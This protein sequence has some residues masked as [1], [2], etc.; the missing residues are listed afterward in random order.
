MHPNAA[1]LEPRASIEHPV[2]NPRA[3]REVVQTRED[4]LHHRV[5]SER[6]RAAAVDS[7]VRDE[8]LARRATTDGSCSSSGFVAYFPA[9]TILTE[10]ASWS[11]RGFSFDA[12]LIAI[13]EAVSHLISSSLTTYHLHIFTDSESAAKALFHTKSGRSQLLSLNSTLRNTINAWTAA[14]LR[15]NPLTGQPEP[16]PSYWG[17]DYLHAPATHIFN[18]ALATSFIRRFGK[19]SIVTF[20]RTARVINNHTFTGAYRAKFR[21]RAE[22][23]TTCPCGFFPRGTPLHDRHHVL[24]ECPFYYRGDISQL[25][26]LLELDPFPKILS[27]LSLNPG[28]FTAQDAPPDTSDWDDDEVDP[29]LELLINLIG[30]LA[31]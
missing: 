14:T 5:A 25:D 24:F 18:P 9:H 17:H 4:R 8:E 27:F 23:P 29:R 19:L 20:A 16:D 6:V 15:A 31:F 3:G 28:A 1:R 21:P 26:H 2:P 12:E 30:D 11:G 13:L 10:Q 22:E 7:D